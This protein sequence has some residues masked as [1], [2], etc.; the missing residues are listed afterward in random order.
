[1][2]DSNASLRMNISCPACEKYTDPGA[3]PGDR[4]KD[5]RFWFLEHIP[6]P[7]PVKGWLVL[8]TN[9]HTEGLVGLNK[10]EAEELG[11]ILNTL[12][13]IL[14][15]ATGSQ[16][17]Y[18]CCFTEVVPHLHFHL[19]PRYHEE[20]KRAADVFLLQKD[21]REGKVEPVDPKEAAAFAELLKTKI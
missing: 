2:K 17:I 5:Y 13:K 15:E 16:Q 11:E 1:M 4:V 9:R 18:L 20:V 10:E 7:V 12:P 3:S 14:K 6:E 19:I 21:V 8:R